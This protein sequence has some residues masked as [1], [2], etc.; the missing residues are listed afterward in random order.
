MD[1]YNTADRVRHWQ[2]GPS[3]AGNSAYM[4]PGPGSFW[5]VLSQVLPQVLSQK[6]RSE[7][8]LHS[9]SKV[10]A[11]HKLPKYTGPKHIQEAEPEA[12]LKREHLQHNSGEGSWPGAVLKGGSWNHGEGGS[13][14]V[15]L[16]TIQA[17]LGAS[18]S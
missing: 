6:H 16:V 9:G 17:Y 4:E 3:R 10:P 1:G 12:G 2:G 13:P 15:R 14:R 5:K 7:A 8:R 11:R 18:E